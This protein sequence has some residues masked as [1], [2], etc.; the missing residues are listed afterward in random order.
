MARMTGGKAET[1]PWRTEKKWIYGEEE[2][3]AG[4]QGRGDWAQLDKH[5]RE[6]DPREPFGEH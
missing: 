6:N 3:W 2:L 1:D 5:C 4:K